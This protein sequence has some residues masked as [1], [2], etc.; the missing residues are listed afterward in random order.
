MNA[1]SIKGDSPEAINTALQQ[2]MADGFRPALAIVFLTNVAEIDA[3]TDIL[4]KLRINVFG[5]STS[6]KFNE[7]G[8]DRDGI[9]V[10]LLDMNPAHFRIVLED[11]ESPAVGYVGARKVG[12]AGKDSFNHP[13]FII[14]TA[15]LRIA[16]NDIIRGILDNAGME[17]PVIG[18]MA[19]EPNHFTGLVFSN[20]AKS[21]SGL[22]ALIID[23][24]NRF[25]NTI[26]INVYDEM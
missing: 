2:T 16:G 10:M 25:I 8:I 23:E 7:D 18:G 12:Q 13:A 11:F 15:D 9:I 20:H 17:V 1:R 24:D 21:T 14:A 26:K 4:A 6:E 22:L 19:G 3:I 5:A